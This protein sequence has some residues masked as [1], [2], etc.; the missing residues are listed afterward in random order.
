MANEEGSATGRLPK[1]P[2]D[3]GRKSKNAGHAGVLRYLS[4]VE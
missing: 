3:K 2:A 1:T 4:I